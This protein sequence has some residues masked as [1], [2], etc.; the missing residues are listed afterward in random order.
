MH[1]LNPGIRADQLCDE[2][3]LF[4]ASAIDKIWELVSSGAQ[5]L[6]PYH[7]V[8]FLSPQ[9]YYY[10]VNK[11]A[12]V[13]A[14][15]YEVLAEAT[16]R[17]L[18]VGDLFRWETPYEWGLYT[19]WYNNWEPTPYQARKIERRFFIHLIKQNTVFYAGEQIQLQ[20]YFNLIYSKSHSY[21]NSQTDGSD[22][23][24]DRQNAPLR[25][26]GNPENLLCLH[27]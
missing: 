24:V 12:Y 15:Q 25:T 20:T 16:R 9:H 19:E 22:R 4:E 8:T 1:F 2:R 13:E 17:A 23:S 26:A 6:R 3:L 21:E 14:R 18:N 11:L 7:I 10:F 27:R 5:N